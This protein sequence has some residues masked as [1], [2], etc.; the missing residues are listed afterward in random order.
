VCRF[1]GWEERRAIEASTFSNAQKGDRPED[2]DQLIEL[3]WR[4]QPANVNEPEQSSLRR[5][6][7]RPHCNID[8]GSKMLLDDGS[9]AGEQRTS[10]HLWLL[11]STKVA[12]K[13]VAPEC[14][15]SLVLHDALGDFGASMTGPVQVTGNR[16]SG[17]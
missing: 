14:E 6:I 2:A 5:S 11:L 4:N 16:Q 12:F 15:D 8:R 10:R 13:I 3:R 17:R 1:L 7:V 9:V